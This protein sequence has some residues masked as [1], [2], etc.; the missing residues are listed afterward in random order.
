LCVIFQ[1]NCY[2]NVHLQLLIQYICS[3]PPYVEVISSSAIQ[4]CAMPWWHGPA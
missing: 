3:Y 2:Y 4:G 1:G